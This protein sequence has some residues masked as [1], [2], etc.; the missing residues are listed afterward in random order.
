MKHILIVDDDERIRELLKQ[1]LQENGFRVSEAADTIEARL[2]LS[3]FFFDLI[4]LDLMLPGEDGISFA[5]SL[6][7]KKTCPILMLSALGETSN[8]IEGLEVGADDYL[9]KPFEPRELLL[10]I[11][12]LIK[13]SEKQTEKAVVNIGSKK[14]NIQTKNFKDENE[15]DIQLTGN[16]RK[17]LEVMVKN[18]GKIISR[19]E[20]KTILGNEINERTIDVQIKRLR[21]K[22]EQSPSTPLYLKTVRGEGYVLYF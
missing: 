12:N 14:Y 13:R 20:F 3:Y 10:R 15:R 7:L 19:E 17:I 11:A 8:R 2:A 5:D 1:Y 21:E 4:I 16:E 9:V 22:I 6:R 18:N